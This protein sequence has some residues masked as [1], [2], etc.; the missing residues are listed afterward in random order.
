MRHA[1]KPDDATNPDLSAA[2]RERAEALP[3]RI[4]TILSGPI[5]FIFAAARSARSDRPAETVTP[6]SQ[7]S[8]V[9]IDSTFADKDYP[10]LAAQL[11]SHQTYDDQRI[12][13]CWHHEH[14]PSFAR[15]LG[16]PAGSYPT[17]WPGSVF[18]LILKFD[19]AGAV[20]TV[21]ELTQ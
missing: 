5:N 12:V 7:A 15:N 21:T 9:E 11:L 10:E 14:I 13:V 4:N 8:G 19:W 2:G 1:E 3:H 18:D 17:T 20:P 16:A 6:L